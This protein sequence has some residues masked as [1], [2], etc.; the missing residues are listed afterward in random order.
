M[1]L[2]R[3]GQNSAHVVNRYHIFT[4]SKTEISKVS[5]FYRSFSVRSK[6][7]VKEPL[8][9]VPSMSFCPDFI[10]IVFK[11]YPDFFRNFILYPDFI[12]IFEKIWIKSG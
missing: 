4:L 2:A 3:K 1:E 6:K 9:K 11:F 8:I 10:Q 7:I 5:E 12:L